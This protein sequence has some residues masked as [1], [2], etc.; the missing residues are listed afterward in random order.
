M[1]CA[2]WCIPSGIHLHLYLQGN[3]CSLP[4]SALQCSADEDY[5]AAMGK[6]QGFSSRGGFYGPLGCSD[7]AGDDAEWQGAWD[8]DHA[9]VE[10]MAEMSL[11][12]GPSDREKTSKKKRLQAAAG[13]TVPAEL[14][15]LRARNR[16]MD[17]LLHDSQV[18]EMSR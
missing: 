14:E 15:H 9:V 2:Q 18:W 16:G 11:D 4:N 12:E 8:T 17:D 1:V 13:P 3:D 10:G 5:D 6:V 7:G